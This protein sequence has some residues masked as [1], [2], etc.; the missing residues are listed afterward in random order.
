MAL[1]I[2]RSDKDNKI[3]IIIKPSMF[4]FLFKGGNRINISFYIVCSI[5][6]NI[7]IL[8]KQIN[9]IPGVY[10]FCFYFESI[11]VFL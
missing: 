8:K 7:F 3:E 1:N 11:I 4:L 9:F 2:I 6:Y 5:T 10:L